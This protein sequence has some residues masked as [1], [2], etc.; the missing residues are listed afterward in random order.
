MK[1]LDFINEYNGIF[2][3][4][5]S[6]VVSVATCFYVYLTFRLLKETRRL[7][8]PDIYLLVQE[9]ELWPEILEL[10]VQ[11][12]GLGPAYN[13]SLSCDPDFKINDRE[14]FSHLKFMKT[15]F[16]YIG[17]NQKIRVAMML[18]NPDEKT[19][20]I[21]P[22]KF[23]VKYDDNSQKKVRHDIVIDFNEYAKLEVSRRSWKHDIETHL[24]KIAD[25]LPSI[26][27]ATHE[28]SKKV[29]DLSSEIKRISSRI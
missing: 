24:R 11:N 2:L 14:M 16:K 3:A 21:G 12:T 29:G 26:P 1:I 5:F 7:R 4:V 9:C 15:G 23:S 10:I 8:E 18:L 28:V 27:A 17:P 13:I 19:E 6:F 20:S 22:I 25:N